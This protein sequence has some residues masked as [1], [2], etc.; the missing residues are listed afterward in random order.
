M[1]QRLEFFKFNTLDCSETRDAMMKKQ[2][3]NSQYRQFRLPSA[4]SPELLEELKMLKSL[5]TRE[6]QQ[7]QA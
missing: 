3:N 4:L 2:Q 7:A 6:Q 5:E 1:A